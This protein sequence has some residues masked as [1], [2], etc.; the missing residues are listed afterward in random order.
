[1]SLLSL[2]CGLSIWGRADIWA[3]EERGSLPWVRG[4]PG[5]KGKA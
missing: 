3:A 2:D 1:M 4:F 5:R